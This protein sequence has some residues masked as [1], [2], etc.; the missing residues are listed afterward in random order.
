M[1]M[2]N[3]GS[4]RHNAYYDVCYSVYLLHSNGLIHGNICKSYVFYYKKHFYLSDYCQYILYEGNT[5]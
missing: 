1:K 3:K 4:I 5:K 2:G